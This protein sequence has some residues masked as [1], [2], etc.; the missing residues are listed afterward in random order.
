[1]AEVFQEVN[2]NLA[3]V[4][5]GQAFAYRKYLKNCDARAYLAAEERASRSRSGVWQQKGGITRPWQFRRLRR[6]DQR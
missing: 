1:V 2:I 4:D 5:H 3:L 6:G